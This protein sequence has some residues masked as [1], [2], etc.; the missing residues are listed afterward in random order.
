[1]SEDR[2]GEAGTVDWPTVSVVIPTVDRPAELR[3]A[4]L[5]VLGQDY[6]GHVECIVVFDGTPVRLPDVPE[7]P[8]RSLRGLSNT[9][10]KGL[11]GNRNTGYLEAAGELVCPLDDDD[12][13][14]PAKLTRQ[15]EL[16]RQHPTA[17]VAGSGFYIHHHGR[18]FLREGSARPLQLRDLLLD[19]H[20]EVNSSTYVVRRRQMLDDIGLIDED[21][22]GGYAEDYEFL[23]RAARTGPV[24]TA[25]EPLARIYWHDKSFFTSDWQTIDDAL[26][27][28]LDVVPEFADEPRGAARLHGQLAMANAALGRRRPA[29][30]WAGKALRRRPQARQAWAA[31]AVASGLVSAEQV[32]GLGRRLGRGV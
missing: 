24:V 17:N 10:R 13:W 9:R 26:R 7:V 23:L 29:L 1:M 12:E 4:V 15:V 2:R 20:M 27:H 21:L 18:D 14:L 6:L 3:R 11:A 28:V 19:R 16:L 31:V 32:V 30:A 8:R 22:P 25:V 5:S